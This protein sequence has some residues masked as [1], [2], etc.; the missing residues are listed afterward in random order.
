MVVLL[1]A[2]CAA[3][4]STMRESE[5]ILCPINVSMLCATEHLIKLVCNVL[6]STGSWKCPAS[7][8]FLGAMWTTPRLIMGLILVSH[9]KDRMS[10]NKPLSLR[11]EARRDKKNLV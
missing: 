8:M 3:M 5:S 1:V 7:M 4:P 9:L 11:K 10:L 2:A 6:C